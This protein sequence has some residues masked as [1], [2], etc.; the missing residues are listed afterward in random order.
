MKVTSGKQAQAAVF[1][2]IRATP[3]TRIPGKLTRR[4]YITLKNEACE[5]ACGEDSSYEWSGDFGHLA[6]VTGATEYL[7]ITTAAG[8]PLNYVPETAPAAFNPAITAATTDYQTNKK[9]AEWEEKRENW[10]TLC[11]VQDGLCANF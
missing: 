2:T 1:E 11:G 9:S 4:D 10:F 6:V 3:F 8:T 7:T 5:A